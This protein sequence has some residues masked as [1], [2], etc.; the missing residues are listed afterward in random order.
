MIPLGLLSPSTRYT[1]CNYSNKSLIL[2]HL[3]QFFGAYYYFSII[4][5]WGYPGTI[6]LISIAIHSVK[7]IHIHVFNLRRIIP[8]T[9][10]PFP[11]TLQ[12]LS[13]CWIQ[14]LPGRVPHCSCITLQSHVNYHSTINPYSS[15]HPP[16]NISLTHVSFPW[17]SA[18]DSCSCLWLH[19]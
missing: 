8:C 14:T 19:S 17:R 1:L 15:S 13:A 6:S 2:F 10:C 12:F 7:N 3:Y 9:L 11:L 4:N 16:S 18:H 5:R